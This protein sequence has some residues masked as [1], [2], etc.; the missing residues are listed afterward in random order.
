MRRQNQ[1]KQ[2]KSWHGCCTYLDMNNIIYTIANDEDGIEA[3]VALN[4]N[5]FAVTLKD[6]DANEIIGIAIIYK[7]ADDAIAKANEISGIGR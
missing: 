1:F 6:T 5:G 7:N 4:D 3:R 2:I